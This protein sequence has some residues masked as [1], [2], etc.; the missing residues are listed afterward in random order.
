MRH[1]VIVVFCLLLAATLACA[2]TA[3]DIPPAPVPDNAVRVTVVFSNDVHGSIMRTAA[4]FLNPEFPPELG[5]AASAALIIR[6]LRERARRDGQYFAMVDA[7]DI[8]QGAPVGTVT[9]GKAVVDYYNLIGMDAVAVGNHDLD[10]GYA[11]LDTLISRSRFTWLSANLHE[12]ESGRQYPGTLPYVIKDFGGVKIGIIGLATISTKYMSFPKNIATITFE[13]EIPALQHSMA[14]AKRDGAQ[15]I[16]VLFHHGIQFDEEEN[17]RRLVEQELHGGFTKESVG[18]AQELAHRV[19]GIDVLFAGHIHIGK[20]KGWVHPRHHTLLLQNYGHGGNL[21]VVDLFL[22]K[23]TGRLIDYKMPAEQ[24]MLLLLQ[25]EQWLRDPEL[26]A[27]IQAIVDTVE[28]GMDE[29]IGEAAAEFF[30]GDGN[31]P[32][33]SLV[34]EAMLEYAGTD[35]ALQNSGGVRENLVPGAI[36]RRQIFHIEPF[37]NELVRCRVSGAFLKELLEGKTSPSRL[38]LGLGGA[39]V[40]YDVS[41]PE[42]ARI[43]RITFYNGR[44]FHP[45]TLYTVATSDYLLMG[46][47][48]MEKLTEI[49]HDQVDWLGVRISD[50]ITK[51][52]ERHTPVKPDTRARWVNAAK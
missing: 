31:A 42:G 49:P 3:D 13:D 11:N 37:G 16:W 7:G 45:D 9:R 47:S 41:R 26:D 22:D 40:I 14:E 29:V 15:A 36:T 24:S 34:A 4:E 12:R 43:G 2:I 6:A 5:G 52:I 27:R 8:Y 18:D 50:A 21:G 33:V 10:N 44:V 1:P 25:E 38:G 46:N 23:A 30:R 20:A 35:I 48:G 17:Y 28:R 19:A 51:Y 39:V 32:M